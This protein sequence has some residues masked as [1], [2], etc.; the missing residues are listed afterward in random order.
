MYLLTVKTRPTLKYLQQ[1]ITPQYA[2]IWREI[3]V[4][5]NLSDGNLSIIEADNLRNI[6]RCC[7]VML[8]SWLEVDTNASWE[9]L[10]TA[11]AICSEQYNDQGDY[12]LSLAA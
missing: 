9:M 12:N 11:I 7:N 2:K 10:F 4:Q 5:L 3:G 1:H 6:K 8:S